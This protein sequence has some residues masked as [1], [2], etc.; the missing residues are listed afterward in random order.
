MSTVYQVVVDLQ[1]RGD[2][3]VTRTRSG[4]GQLESGFSRVKDLARD[5]GTG[6]A[7]AL[8]RVATSAL[9]VGST[10]AKWGAVAGVGA[11]TYGVVGL[12]SELEKT[13]I[14][15]ASIFSAN[16]QANGINDGLSLA[17][18]TIQ[19]MR[20]DAAMLPGEFTDLMNIMQT[21]AIPAFQSGMNV[22]ALR[23]FSSKLMATGVVASMPLD[24]V[25]REAAQLM[26][27]RSGAHNVLGMKLMNL[28]GESAEQFNKMGAVERLSKMNAEL[29]KYKGSIAVFGTSWEG[30]SSTFKDN[31]KE[32]LRLA[33]SPLFDHM[34]DALAGAN[35]WF[36]ANQSA[37]MSWSQRIGDGLADS[38]E[39][40][41]AKIREWGPLITDFASGAYEK[42]R[43]IW[44][45]ARPAVNAFSDAFRRALEDPNGTIDKL[46]FL[47]K[48]WTGVKIGG[49]FGGALMASGLGEKM[50]MGGAEHPGLA[51][52]GMLAMGMG[53]GMGKLA[54]GAWNL[55]KG[56][57][58]M[59][60]GA[61]AASAIGA[62]TAAVSGGTAMGG[63]AAL[64]SAATALA[65]VLGAAAAAAGGLY[66]AFDQWAALQSDLA[67][68]ATK[69][70]SA[71][72]EW[73]DRVVARYRDEATAVHDVNA[74]M[75][76]Y[77]KTGEETKAH[78][79]EL[80]L[81]ARDASGALAAIRDPNEDLYARLGGKDAWNN[82][83]G[84]ERFEALGKLVD[85]SLT[86][87]GK[88]Q[89]APKHGGGGGG[90]HI[91]KV[92]IVVT[93]NKEPNRVA[94]L[95]ADEVSKLR[96]N[97]KTSPDAPNFSAKNM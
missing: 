63:M 64:G 10:I 43:M 97:P 70:Q 2:L 30:I 26:Q 68:D 29:D 4:L 46:L 54:S 92:E 17:A 38:F 42:F 87:G 32:S 45:E 89:I 50:L 14:S 28:S 33:T 90:T 94:R 13:K 44:I 20:R 86:R 35:A 39:F 3:G 88:G 62:G 22:D 84:R 9:N 27:G 56:A 77:R 36:T 55:G 5:I 69:N 76:A 83:G 47:A 96:R 74:M 72:A 16:G 81:A 34:K 8:D 40:G 78:L 11:V 15:L 52:A 37:V 51:T 65:P 49:A 73:A 24:Q 48:V 59:Y 57:A 6:A 95:V 18:D 23:E 41:L 19:K 75:D 80:A 85:A 25:A 71:Q 58:G 31:V 79:L 1:T 93:G 67:D 12:N 7:S 61:Q 21:T 53:G 82:M 60:A 91:Q 66:L